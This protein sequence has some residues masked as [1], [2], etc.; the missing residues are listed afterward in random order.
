M[1][2]DVRQLG[3]LS[4][5]FRDLYFEFGNFVNDAFVSTNR[6]QVK[7][8]NFGVLTSDAALSFIITIT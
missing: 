2:S 4:F 1:L 5:I 6:N 8:F 7:N 3:R